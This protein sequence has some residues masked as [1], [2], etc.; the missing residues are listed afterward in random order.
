[1]TGEFPFEGDG[2]T[3]EENIVADPLELK[4]ERFAGVSENAKDMLKRLLDKDPNSRLT[5]YGA[6]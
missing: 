6:T 5:A 3:L 4:S 1:M 2:D